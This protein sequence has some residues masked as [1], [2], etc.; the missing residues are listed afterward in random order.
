[1][2]MDEG[3]FPGIEDDVN[4]GM[5]LERQVHGVKLHIDEYWTPASRSMNETGQ[6]SRPT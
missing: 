2:D 1:M 6:P 3:T 4:D 5:I